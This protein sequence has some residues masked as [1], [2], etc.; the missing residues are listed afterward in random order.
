MSYQCGLHP[1]RYHMHHI[2]ITL[3]SGWNAICVRDI[4]PRDQVLVTHDSVQQGGG[5]IYR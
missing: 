1:T 5:I 2:E 4:M 3:A